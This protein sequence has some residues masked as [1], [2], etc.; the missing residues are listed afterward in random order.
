MDRQ[1]D[2]LRS[3]GINERCLSYDDVL[4]NIDILLDL[5]YKDANDRLAFRRKES[6][7]FLEGE[8]R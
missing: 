8:L 1:T 7:D 3:L 4:N 2:L 6:I 5:D